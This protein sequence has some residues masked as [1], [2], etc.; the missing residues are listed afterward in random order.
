MTPQKDSRTKG[1]IHDDWRMSSRISLSKPI[2]KRVL[3]AT[4]RWQ[5]DSGVDQIGRINPAK[6]VEK[7]VLLSIFEEYLENIP[8][9]ENTDEEDLANQ[10]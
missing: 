1:R 6:P 10:Y 4:Q 2:E 3:P 7:G 5:P 9:Q 8:P